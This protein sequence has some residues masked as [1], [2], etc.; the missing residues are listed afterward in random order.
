MSAIVCIAVL[1]LVD[2]SFFDGI[3]F[4]AVKAVIFHLLDAF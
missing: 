1:Y 2:M 3:Y 4:N